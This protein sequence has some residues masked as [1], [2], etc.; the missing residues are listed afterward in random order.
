MR[1]L[2]LLA[3]LRH[4]LRPFLV[5]YKEIMSLGTGNR[6]LPTDRTTL[7]IS[8]I[9]HDLLQLQ[10]LRSFNKRAV[11]QPFLANHAPVLFDSLALH[12]SHSESSSNNGQHS[13]IAKTL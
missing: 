13:V 6:C 3:S 11:S 9:A 1:Y 5:E 8:P 4:P 12:A 7:K 10:L 2:P